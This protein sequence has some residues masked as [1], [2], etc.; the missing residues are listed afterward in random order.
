M[1]MKAEPM[2]PE[3]LRKLYIVAGVI[4][5]LFWGTLAVIA[6]VMLV[7]LGLWPIVVWPFVVYW[8]SG[9]IGRVVTV[10]RTQYKSAQEYNVTFNVTP[11]TS[12]EEIAEAAAKAVRERSIYGD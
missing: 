5:T 7:G 8:I 2:T 11:T 4:G 6:G 3:T 1:K 9:H 10:Y 12:A